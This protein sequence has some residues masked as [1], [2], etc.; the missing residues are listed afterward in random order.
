M[1]LIWGRNGKMIN[2]IPD[3]KKK[4]EKIGAGKLLAGLTDSPLFY[5]KK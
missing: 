2:T 1:I 3:Q 4:N 5:N